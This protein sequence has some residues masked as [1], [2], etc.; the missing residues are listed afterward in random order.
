LPLILHIGFHKTGSTALQEF[1]ER[2]RDNLSGR[3]I[4]VPKGL[5]SW[6]GHPELSWICQADR[7]PWQDRDYDSKDVLEHYRPYLELSRSAQTTVIL[8]SEEFCRLEFRFQTM[9]AVNQI[10]GDYR[11]IVVGYFR[12]PMAFLLSRYRH[13]VQNGH[14]FRSLRDFLLDVGN[15]LSAK[16]DF[17]CQMWDDLLDGRCLFRNYDLLDPSSSI[18]DNFFSLI[19]V[20]DI[21]SPRG[22]TTEIKIDV[23][24]IDVFR[25][26]AASKLPKKDKSL[27][28]GKMF[29][30]SEQLL[31]GDIRALIKS[32]GMAQEFDTLFASLTNDSISTDRTYEEI[33]KR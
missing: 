29:L 21:R 7:L 4:V 8:S 2:E 15:L 12:N 23:R 18:V 33:L 19:G 22:D 26:L 9:A 17:R 5:S 30:I 14:E 31:D 16:F 10:L 25:A 32:A 1:F 20:N 27:L 13:E 28:M 24:M 11:P 6:L 3:N